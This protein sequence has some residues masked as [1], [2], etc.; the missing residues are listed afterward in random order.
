MLTPNNYQNT[1]YLM[2]HG[3]SVA[4]RRGIIA[5]QVENAVNNYGLT[6][7]GCKQVGQS[8][9]R[10]PLGHNTIIVSS[11][12]RRARE[13]A[14]IM[15]KTLSVERAIQFDER[16]RERDFGD[17][18]LSNDENYEAI[19]QAD[20]QPSQ[21]APHSSQLVSKLSSV[22]SVQSVAQRTQALLNDLEAQHQ[23]QNLLLVS[24]GDVLQI[25]LAVQSGLDAHQHRSLQ[26]LANAD[27]R[28][29]PASVRTPKTDAA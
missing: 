12:F 24:H 28:C 16:L 29:C 8:A 22:E 27:I 25:L 2:R 21:S 1:Y 18:E 6:S 9:L 15:A 11:D 3:Q 13:S 7:E 17:F 14:I 5:S 23:G 19:W 10:T 26:A 4:N 20:L